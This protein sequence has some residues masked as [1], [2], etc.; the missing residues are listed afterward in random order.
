MKVLI[1]VILLSCCYGCTV[2]NVRDGMH[3]VDIAQTYQIA[4]NHNCYQEINPIT[5]TLLGKKPKAEAVLIWGIASHFINKEVEKV[6][7]KKF[8]KKAMNVYIGFHML[9]KGSNIKNNF[10][11]GLDGIGAPN[12]NR[13]NCKGR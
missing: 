3:I 6:M 2:S 10:D 1:L 7:T 12:Y 5:R 13:V 4:K 9:E 8:G 11:I